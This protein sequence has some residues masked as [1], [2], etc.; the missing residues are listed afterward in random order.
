MSISSLVVSGAQI[1]LFRKPSEMDDHLSDH[2]N[3]R[4][5]DSMMDLLI[6]LQFAIRPD[7]EAVSQE[8]QV[9]VRKSLRGALPRFPD[10]GAMAMITSRLSERPPLEGTTRLNQRIDVQPR[11]IPAASR[12]KYHFFGERVDTSSGHFISRRF[13]GVDVRNCQ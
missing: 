4:L 6:L 2:C 8:L 3:R 5:C 11:I 7:Q 9:E 10:P 13:S 1:L 12:R